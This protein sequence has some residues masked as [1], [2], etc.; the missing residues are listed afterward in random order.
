MEGGGR[1]GSG[2]GKGGF[3]Q[4]WALPVILTFYIMKDAIFSTFLSEC[5][6]G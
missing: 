3:V 4:S 6:W 5:Y 2:L 1:E